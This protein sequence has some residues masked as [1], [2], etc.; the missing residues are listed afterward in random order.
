MEQ[1]DPGQIH[2]LL[3]PSS[4]ATT[5]LCQPL[6]KVVARLDSLLLVTKSC[7]GFVC[8]QPWNALHPQG[9]VQSLR[10]ALSPR[11]DAFYEKQQ[12]KVSY[13]RCELGYIEEAEGAQFQKDGYVYR[14]GTSWSDWA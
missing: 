5:F 10:D 6:E 7:T 8:T 1:T 4:T 12:V 2:N 11:F 14:Q 3:N 9:N 13:S